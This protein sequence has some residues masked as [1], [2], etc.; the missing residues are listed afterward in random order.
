MSEEDY[1]RIHTKSSRPGLFYGTEK[2]QK[3]KENDT[4][5]NLPLRSI[6]S[7]VG[8]ATYETAKYLVTLLSPLTSSE[9]NI[10]NSYEFVKSI[11]NTKIPNGCKMI[12]FDIKNLFTSVPLDKTIKIILRNP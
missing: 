6:I 7:N 11:Q 5:E 12:S 4:V 2:L 8:T 10:K 3:L 1:K 9:Y